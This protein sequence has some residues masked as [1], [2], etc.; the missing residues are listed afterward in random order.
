M[1][2][3]EFLAVLFLSLLPCLFVPFGLEHEG[4]AGRY[5]LDPVLPVG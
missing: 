4:A 5:S 1:K 3:L 2:G